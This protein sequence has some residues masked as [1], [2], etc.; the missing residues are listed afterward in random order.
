MNSQ[1]QQARG[2]VF[3]GNLNFL[4]ANYLDN[5]VC[6]SGNAAGT[7]MEPFAPVHAPGQTPPPALLTSF[8]YALVA[9]SSRLFTAGWI[10]SIGV[11]A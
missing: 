4:A 6:T 9:H 3:W 10:A 1:Q 8:S 11:C 7:G 5:T 2:T